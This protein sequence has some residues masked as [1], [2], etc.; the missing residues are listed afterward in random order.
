LHGLRAAVY[1]FGMRRFLLAAVM[2]AAGC[3]GAPSTED[4]SKALDHLIELE[5]QNAG[6]NKGLTEEMK[7]D[8]QKQKAAVSEAQRA[9]FMEACVKKTPKDIVDCTLGAQSI[10]QAAKCDEK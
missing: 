7:A 8:L 9:Q 5:I 10:E 2:S 6:G 1:D 3:G 4:C